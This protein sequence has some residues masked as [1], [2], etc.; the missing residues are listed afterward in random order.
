MINAASPVGSKPSAFRLVIQAP[1]EGWG[2]ARALS[3]SGFEILIRTDWVRC[4]RLLESEQAPDALIVLADMVTADAVAA[5]RRWHYAGWLIP[6]AVLFERPDFQT[7]ARVWPLAEMGVRCLFLDGTLASAIRE[8][9]HSDAQLFTSYLSAR[10]PTASPCIRSLLRLLAND[11]KVVDMSTGDVAATI[12]SSR[13]VLYR[14]L[15]DAG[16]P[17]V[18][19][20]QFAVR[21]FPAMRSF[22]RSGNASARSQ[23]SRRLECLD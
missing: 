8:L 17:S 14:E 23:R 21:L 2:G 10:I 1:S 22:H 5:I 11:R 6:T 9:V 13:P 3:G 20:L 12:G 18:E 19:Q 15:R 16:W 7:I 4:L